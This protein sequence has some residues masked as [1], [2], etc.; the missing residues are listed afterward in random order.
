M[1][2]GYKQANNLQWL[3]FTLRLFGYCTRCFAFL[4]GSAV[5]GGRASEVVRASHY[6]PASCHV[7]GL[8][9]V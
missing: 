6:I 3:P 2:R 7:P 9:A 4:L 8:T 5:G 1:V